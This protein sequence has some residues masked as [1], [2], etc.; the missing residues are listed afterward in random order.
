MRM[1]YR[2]LAAGAL[3]A[4][5][6]AYRP[7]SADLPGTEFTYQGNIEQ[8]GVPAEG[9]FDFEFELFDAVAGTSISATSSH[10]GIEVVAG[11]FTVT[12]VDFGEDFDIATVNAELEVRVR[13]SGSPTFDTLTPRTPFNAAPLA[14][15]LRGVGVATGTHGS[16]MRSYDGADISAEWGTAPTGS[17]SYRGWAN[18]E[19]SNVLTTLLDAD[20]DNDSSNG[21]AEGRLLVRGAGSG[22]VGGVVQVGDETG[23]ATIQLLGGVAGDLAV[24]FP[25]D[26][27][28]ADETVDEPGV[29]SDTVTG[30]ATTLNPVFGGPTVLESETI[31]CPGDGYV[32][33]LGTCQ[34]TAA[35]SAGTRSYYEFGVTDD[36]SGF[37]PNQDVAI[38]IPASEP[39]GNRAMAVTVHGLF[40]VTAGDHYF[41]MLGREY[42]GGLTAE[43]LDVQFTVIYFATA[44]GAVTGTFAGAED[45][46]EI[47]GIDAPRGYLAGANQRIGSASDQANHDGELEEVRRELAELRSLLVERGILVS[48]SPAEDAGGPAG[49]R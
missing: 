37:P 41:A 22:A 15:H 40:P 6:V 49:G 44:Y 21:V 19:G 48:A 47:V 36:A 11:V 34:L 25:L 7:A 27:V 33:V 38:T 23:S 14:S 32:L 2:T 42:E 3:V 10:S 29:A 18:P 20:R 39:D 4:G 31:S 30:L 8:A 45:R 35:H 12:D 16:F 46:D 5:L 43:V 26:A 13:A 24:Q 28:N 17:G 1:T 9:S